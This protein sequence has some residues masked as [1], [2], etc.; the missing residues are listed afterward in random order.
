MKRFIIRRLFTSI[1][2]LVGVTVIV[3]SMSRMV[4]DPRILL[5]P[6]QGYG[7]NQQEW[8]AA[9]SRLH[10][11]RAIPVQ[12]GYWIADILR[13]NLGMDL[14]DRTPIAPKLTQKF[15][16]TL[17]LSLS[18]WL[19]A[20]VVGVPLGVL[21]AVKRNSLLDYVARAIAIGG[22]SLPTF[23]VGILAILLFAVWLGWLP[24]GTMGEGFAIRN[25][26]LPTIILAWLPLAG[27]VRLVRSAMLDIMDSEYIKL[28]RA[29][30]VVEWTVIWKH[31]FRNAIIA[32]LTFAGLTLAG[33]IS[34]SIAV[35]T[36][37]SWPGIARYAVEAVWNNN[38]PVLA[39]V[40]LLFTVAFVVANFLVDVLYAY[41]DPRIRLG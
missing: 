12:Y 18:A 22:Q 34:G 37:F 19:L 4:G 33:L 9:A 3:F 24:V 28:A 26:I 39:I 15:G 21:S 8:D 38:L 20:I 13:G 29:K 1:L 17:T 10:L 5:L 36:V 31:G 14:A 41:L 32:P 35:E 23:W 6:Q 30:G 27:Y 7:M 40:T 11:D 2:A 16:P 25:L